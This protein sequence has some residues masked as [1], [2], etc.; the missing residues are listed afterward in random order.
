LYENHL[1]L[2]FA[3]IVYCLLHSILAGSGF[4]SFLEK[5]PGGLFR[6]YRLAYTIFAALTLLLLLYFQYSFP[7]PLLFR[8]ALLKY[9]SLVIFVAPGIAIMMISIIKY[10]KLLSGVLSLYQPKPAAAL[11]LDGVHKYVRHPLYSGTLLFVWGLFFIFPFLNN[12]VA[13]TVITGYVLVGI[14]IEEKKLLREFGNVYE[15]YRSEVP[16]LVPGW[17]AWDNKKGQP[18]GHP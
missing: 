5:I 9:I 11:M 14:R 1:L 13:V 6:Y 15:N 7:S 2:L 17:K 8:F 18:F 4:K 3:W 16:T 12:L 10:F